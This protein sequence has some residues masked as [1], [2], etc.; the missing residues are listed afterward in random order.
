MGTKTL[1]PQQC[2]SLKKHTEAINMSSVNPIYSSLITQ[3]TALLW[4]KCDQQ[5]EG[6]ITATVHGEP[7]DLYGEYF[8]FDNNLYHL[9]IFQH[10]ECKKTDAQ[11]ISFYAGEALIGQFTGQLAESNRFERLLH[12][13][14]AMNA[15]EKQRL[16]GF[17]TQKTTESYKLYKS[18]NIRLLCRQLLQEVTNARFTVHNSYFLTPNVLYIEGEAE[19]ARPFGEPNILMLSEQFYEKGKSRFIQLSENGFAFIV[20]FNNKN[21]AEKMLGCMISY[22]YDNQFSSFNPFTP[23]NAYGL[24]FTEYLNHKPPYQ[25]QEIRGIICRTLLDYAN[26]KQTEIKDLIYKL[27]LYVHMPIEHCTDPN[28]PFNLHFERIFTLENDGL[29]MC[30]W[31][32]DPHNLLEKIEIHTDLGFNFTCGAAFFRTER[33][34]VREAFQNTAHG[35]NDDN[36]GF[37]AFAPLPLETSN[38]LKNIAKLHSASFTIHIKGGITYNIQPEIHNIDPRTARDVVLKIVAGEKV[39]EQMLLDCIGPAASTLQRLCMNEVAVKAVYEMGEQVKNPRISLSIPLYK[40][41]DFLKVQFA[42]MSGDPTMKECELIYVL[43]SPWQEAEVRDFLREYSHLYQ[44]PV[45]LVVMQHNSG[46]AAA[47]NTGTKYARG[48]YIILLNSDVFPCKAGWATEMADFY[49][50]KPNIGALAPKLIYEDDSLQ[51]AGMFF[52]K[53]TFPDWINLHYYKGYPRHYA[54]AAISRPVPAVT[55]ACLMMSRKLWEDIGRLSEDYVVGDFEDSD[56]CLKC[57]DM[58]LENWYFAD[59]ELYH[60]ERQSVPLNN[61]YADSLAWRYNARQH[62]QRWDD[63]ITKLMSIYGAGL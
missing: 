10:E 54:P 34:D 41:L 59:A 24:E 17:L 43:D 7:A 11:H 28:I 31:I 42:T 38:A 36:M 29:F 46:Y 1:K 37:I 39:S 2:C 22:S 53:T 18:S 58:G 51:H 48:E 25:R 5:Y 32:K 30:G 62:T 52:A 23:T 12:M 56:L 27:Q 8:T 33:P 13:I 4:V 14:S 21:I 6:G 15:S 26:A 35:G 50:S 61:S 45:K 47:S 60:L 63:I 40:R 3:D 9:S 19:G 57:A 55:G 16:L 20:M 49:A 44:L